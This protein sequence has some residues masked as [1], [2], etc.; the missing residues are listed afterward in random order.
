MKIFFVMAA[1]LLLAA[2]T[3]VTDYHNACMEGFASLAD[4]V[5]C[6]KSNVA[7]SEAVK[8]DTLVQE[9]LATGDLLVQQV[10]D[11]KL[12]EKAARVKFIAAL[13]RIDRIALE[14]MALRARA[15]HLYHRDRPRFTNC[16]R[17]GE[18]VT[19]QTY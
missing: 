2:C 7:Q 18:S 11:G 10:A 8:D 6:V 9:Y 5:A 16:Q 19:C 15:D 1:V 13:N 12:S 14:N 3:T 4:Q 17:D